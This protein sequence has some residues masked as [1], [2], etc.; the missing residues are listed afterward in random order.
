MSDDESKRDSRRGFLE[1]TTA[2][3]AGG[4][5]AGELAFPTVLRSAPSSQTLRVGL[6]GCGGRGTGAALQALTADPNTELTAVG[7]LFEEQAEKSLRALQARHPDRVRVEPRRRYLGFDA[8]QK[9]IDSGV[10]VLLLTTPPGFR[11]IHL[12]AAVEAGKHVFAEITAAV[13]APGIRTVIAAAELA[14]QRNL[15]LGAGFCWR[16]HNALRAARQKIK[17]GAIGEVRAVY[18]TYLR[19]SLS[20]KH[21][22]DKKPDDWTDLQW[23]IRNWHNYTWLSGD[24][25][26]LLSGAHSTDKMAWWLDDRMPQRAVAVGGRQ[27][28]DYGNIFDHACVAYEYAGGIRGFLA[29]RGIDGC[30]SENADYIIGT[31]GVC[32]IG[33][34]YVP[35]ITGQTQWRYTGKPSDMY[36]TEHNELFASIRAGKPINEG[37]RYAQTTLMAL[38]GRMSAY[39]GQEITWEQALNSQERLMPEKLD[40]TTKVNLPPPAEPGKTKFV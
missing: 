27:V 15:A 2:A 28:N 18:A 5:L 6:I 35:E 9:V 20:Q 7:E 12:K 37:V 40:W 23:Q 13:D 34:N 36:Q 10:D 38:M 33:R 4:A 30:H 11:A 19:G 16:Y 31:R 8:Y 1:S 22:G 21:G 26:I 3:V 24:V 25:I 29:C 17:E 32:T 14:K 39:T